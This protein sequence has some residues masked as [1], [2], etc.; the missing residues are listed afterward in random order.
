MRPLLNGWRRFGIVIVMLWF[1][2]VISI[3]FIEYTSKS[4]GFFVFQSLPV[5]IIFS[6]NKIILPDGKVIAMTEEDEFKL[7]Y[8]QE[9]MGKPILPWEIDWAQLTSVPKVIEIRWLR[10]GLFAIF[11]PLIA[12]LLAE[13]SVLAVAWVRCGFSRPNHD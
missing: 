2:A 13:A 8:E 5:G 12:W 1:I 7:R 10:L 9:K 11:A 3:A 6:G 4:D